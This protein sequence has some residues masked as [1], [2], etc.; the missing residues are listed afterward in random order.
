MYG[1]SIP[2][3]R[4]GGDLFEYINFQYRYDIDA[5]IES[6]RKASQESL[7]VSPLGSSNC[8]SGD[9]YVEWLRS[10]PGYRIEL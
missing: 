4:T 1:N 10:R 5:R 3:E 6:A 2:A 7:K 9:D 8:H